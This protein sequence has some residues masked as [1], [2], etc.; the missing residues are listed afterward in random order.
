VRHDKRPRIH[1]FIGTSPSH[2]AKHSLDQ[3]AMA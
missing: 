2:L 1:T 3:N